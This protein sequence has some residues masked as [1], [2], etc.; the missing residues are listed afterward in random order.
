MQTPLIRKSSGSAR[1]AA[2][3]IA[4]LSVPAL[5]VGLAAGV[6]VG[7][8]ETIVNPTNDGRGSYFGIDTDV[9]GDQ[10]ISNHGSGQAAYIMRRDANGA[11]SVEQKLTAPSNFASYPNMCFGCGGV[12]IDGN[13]AAVAAPNFYDGVRGGVVL[14]FEKVDGTWTYTTHVFAPNYA[15][16]RL[17]EMGG[18]GHP[19]ELEGNFLIA[20]G[21][22]GTFYLFERV[23]S[24]A[25]ALRA[26]RQANAYAAFVS[27]GQLLTFNYYPY[28]NPP[29]CVNVERFSSS[30]FSNVQT[31]PCS[32]YGIHS[33][34]GDYMVTYP[35]STGSQKKDVWKRADSGLWS[36]IATIANPNPVPGTYFD[37]NQGVGENGVVA[38][39]TSSAQGVLPRFWLFRPTSTGYQLMD[40]VEGYFAYGKPRFSGAQFINFIHSTPDGR[41]GVLVVDFDADKDQLAKWDE[42]AFGTSP[43]DPDTDDDFW[44]DGTEFRCGSLGT[45]ALSFPLPG[46]TGDLPDRFT[47]GGGPAPAAVAGAIAAAHG[48]IAGPDADGDFVLDVTESRICGTGAIAS[49]LGTAGG[50]AGRCVSASNHEIADNPLRNPAGV[51]AGSTGDA[52]TLVASMDVRELEGVGPDAVSVWELAC[53]VEDANTPDDG[54]CTG[55]GAQSSYTPPGL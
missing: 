40:Y 21:S 2:L 28:T 10:M 55:T 15:Y 34:A 27:E 38:L 18:S 13:I 43:T 4:L 48:P 6:P 50:V 54:T 36:K 5:F 26:S 1:R 19:I 51:F 16:G 7:A 53:M 12:T 24:T 25:W 30:G 42:L 45:D 20:G 3:L 32:M 29:T 41:A 52:D 47:L 37:F 49:A 33:V 44:G 14:L 9:D 31:L 22:T 46:C 39:M 35:D 23:L 11:W 8:T 17:G